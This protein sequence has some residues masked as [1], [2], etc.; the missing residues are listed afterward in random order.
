MPAMP[1]CM[2]KESFKLVFIEVVDVPGVILRVVV[3]RN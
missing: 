2:E 3:E 1:R